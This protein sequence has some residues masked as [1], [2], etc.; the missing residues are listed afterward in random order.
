MIVLDQYQHFEG[1][2]FSLSLRMLILLQRFFFYIP[3]YNNAV[4]ILNLKCHVTSFRHILFWNVVIF[5]SV[6]SFVDKV[7]NGDDKQW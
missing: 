2:C 3:I 6:T 4:T 7:D 1:L 5:V